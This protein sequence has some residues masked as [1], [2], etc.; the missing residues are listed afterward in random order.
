MRTFVKLR[1]IIS[2]N[3]KITERLKEIENKLGEHD[4]NIE[5][6]M[7]II[8]ELIVPP[9]PTRKRIGFKVKE[10]RVKYKRKE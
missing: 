6:I 4:G 8:K 5:Q 1:E 2:S 10:K 9:N 7:T 3:S